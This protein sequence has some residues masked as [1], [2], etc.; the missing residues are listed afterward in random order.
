MQRF[1]TSFSKNCCSLRKYL[2]SPALILLCCLTAN[3]ASAFELDVK[4]TKVTLGGYLKT[5]INYD[6]DGTLNNNANH[7]TDGD[8]INAYD[9]PLD[10]TKY[11]DKDDYS[12]TARESRAFL[13]TKTDSDIGTIST[14][15]EADFNGDT[16]GSGTWSNSRTLRLR[17]AYG[18]IDLG[19]S[20]ILVGQDWSTFMDFA[21][22][23]PVMDLSGDP[24][25]P[26]L[27]QPMV[28]YQYNF[29]P[30]HYLSIAAENP[31]SG[32]K[33]NSNGQLFINNFN[34]DN[35]T[36]PDVIVK[37]FWANKNFSIS[38]K[39]LLRKL[40]L[41]GDSTLGW[42]AS[43]TS[44]V[45]FGD[46]HKIYLGL[47]YGDG[48]G[49]Y[50]GLG[51]NAGAGLTDSGDIET[52]KL[53]SINGGVTFHL[54]DDLNWTTGCGYS[55]NDDDAYKGND[56]VLSGNANKNAFSAHTTLMWDITPSVQYAVGM[57]WYKQ[58]VM[59]GRDGEMYRVQNYLKFSF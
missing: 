57:S 12:M 16:G 59:D 46:G 49:R 14:R 45:S 47:T 39:V 21:A 48:I 7:P 32:L 15:F 38:P 11:A 9:V 55:E 5:M 41:D 25:Q 44:S 30:G 22:A 3:P 42:G 26:F 2:A 53:A 31:D 54:R 58:E 18:T 28:R 29:E 17:L 6:I 1:N 37:Y 33:A 27:R 36:L 43:L 35:N 56:A 50:A 24:G 13:R 40:E 23:V 19:K 4:D 34:T 10:G 52:V 20:L 8:I 51:L